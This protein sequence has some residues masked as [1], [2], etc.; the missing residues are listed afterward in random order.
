MIVNLKHQKL[1]NAVTTYKSIHYNIL[2]KSKEMCKKLQFVTLYP[3]YK[4]NSYRLKVAIYF[5][6]N[7]RVYKLSILNV[8][9]TYVKVA[10]SGW[11]QIVSKNGKNT[12]KIAIL[13]GII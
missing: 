2:H 10:R 1:K 4:A 3:K 12:P 13:Y 11:F 6:I 5:S 7:I 9:L 8:N